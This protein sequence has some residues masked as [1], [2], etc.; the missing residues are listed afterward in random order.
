MVL[1]VQSIEIERCNGEVSREAIHNPTHVNSIVIVRIIRRTEIVQRA[2]IGVAL[3]AVLALDMVALNAGR[4]THLKYA[5]RQV[6]HRQ[7]ERTGN[8]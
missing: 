6:Q 1:V 7:L 4:G 5:H 3:G 2:E 8:E